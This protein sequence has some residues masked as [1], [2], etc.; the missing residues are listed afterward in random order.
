MPGLS[1]VRRLE[2]VGFRSWPATNTH[3]DGAWAIRLTAGHPAKRLNS[4]NP[5]DPAD[6]SD[7]ERR[8]ERAGERFRAFGRPLIFRQTPLAPLDLENMLDARGWRRFDE[9]IVMA[10]DLAKVSLDGAIDHLPVK[11]TGRWVDNIIAM[12]NSSLDLKPGLSELIGSIHAPVGL[13]YTENADR[14][15]CSAAMCVRDNDLAGM[16]EIVTHPDYRKQG[17]GMEIVKASLR[18]AKSHGARRAWLQV[19]AANQPAVNLY[20]SLGFGEVYRYAYRQA[21]DISRS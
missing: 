1:Q 18:W 15:P 21:P 10:V 14:E 2:A 5:L 9:T 4:V 6:H 8:I 17:K 3:Y 19:V 11:D 12:N 13:F 7:L 16:F 20:Q